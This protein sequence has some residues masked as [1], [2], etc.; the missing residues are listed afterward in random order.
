VKEGSARWMMG[1]LNVKSRSLERESQSESQSMGLRK[2]RGIVT[3]PQRMLYDLVKS[4]TTR[5]GTFTTRNTSAQM[6]EHKKLHT[7]I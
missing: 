6:I 1:W 4:S 7:A 2:P 3:L 5:E